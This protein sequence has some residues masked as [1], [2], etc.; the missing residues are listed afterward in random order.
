MEKVQVFVAEIGEKYRLYLTEAVGKV[1][2][3]LRPATYFEA[4]KSINIDK[5]VNAIIEEQ[6]SLKE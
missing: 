6:Y 4:I 5:W 1:C 2:I 3:T